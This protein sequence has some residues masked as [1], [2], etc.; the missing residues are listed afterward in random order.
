MLGVG[1]A[2]EELAQPGLLNSCPSPERLV[3]SPA[4]P[5]S[6]LWKVGRAMPGAL[7]PCTS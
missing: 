7:L 1:S 4:S 6:E 3:D 5:V 2:R